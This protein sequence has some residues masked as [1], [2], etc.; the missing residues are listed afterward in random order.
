MAG[1]ARTDASTAVRLEPLGPRAE[2]WI[3]LQAAYDLAL[4]R[5]AGAVA[6]MVA[7]DVRNPSKSVAVNAKECH[8]APVDTQRTAAGGE[9][10]LMP[11]AMLS[12]SLHRTC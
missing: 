8:Q 12:I 11:D 7:K 5:I 1:R 3:E 9:G 6:S 10:R 4:A 2:L